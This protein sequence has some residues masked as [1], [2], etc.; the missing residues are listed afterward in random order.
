MEGETEGETPTQIYFFVTSSKSR[1]KVFSSRPILLADVSSCLCVLDLSYLCLISVTAVMVT[2]S[3]LL[4]PLRLLVCSLLF[5]EDYL[6]SVVSV[7]S[8]SRLLCWI[9][10]I[11]VATRPK[12]WV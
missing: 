9:H 1:S 4:L 5:I 6:Y 3:E 12:S 10:P 2:F 7:L 11:P 8:Y